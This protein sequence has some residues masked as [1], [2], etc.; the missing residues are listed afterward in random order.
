MKNEHSV[1][2]KKNIKIFSVKL[3]DRWQRMCAYMIYEKID[4]MPISE[5]WCITIKYSHRNEHVIMSLTINKLGLK[6]IPEKTGFLR[7][8]FVPGKSHLKKQFYF[9]GSQLKKL[10]FQFPKKLYIHRKA[11]KKYFLGKLLYFY[12][13]A[14]FLYFCIFSSKNPEIIRYEYNFDCFFQLRSQF[15]LT[16]RFLRISRSNFLK[17][18][19]LIEP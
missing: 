13:I 15:K 9:A 2:R 3:E 11:L 6:L 12:K 1:F 19:I 16:L 8:T 4:L 17:N 14:K 5:T 10:F 7:K 18:I